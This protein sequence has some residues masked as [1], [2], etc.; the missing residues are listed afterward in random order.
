M[1][2][3]ATQRSEWK[4][5]LPGN[6]CTV[7]TRDWSCTCM[8]YKSRR[9]P[10]QHI[11]MVTRKVH[12]LNA[13]PTSTV[14]IRWSMKET[15]TLACNLENSLVPLRNVINMVK[16]RQCFARVP[17]S[18]SAHLNASTEIIDGGANATCAV[19]DA[20]SDI[21]SFF[22]QLDYAD[23]MAE[24]EADQEL[25][26]EGVSISGM[27]RTRSLANGVE[28]DASQSDGSNVPPTQASAKIVVEK[29]EDK[30]QVTEMTEKFKTPKV[31]H[32]ASHHQDLAKVSN[33]L[34]QYPVIMT[35]KFIQ[36]RPVMCGIA[37][38]S[39]ACGQS[40]QHAWVIPEPLL[41]KAEASM[42][43]KRAELSTIRK[44]APWGLTVSMGKGV[45]ILHRFVNFM[46]LLLL[47]NGTLTVVKFFPLQNEELLRPKNAN[48]KVSSR[49]PVV[50]TKMGF[51]QA[52]PVEP[53][54]LET[55][56]NGLPHSEAA[57]VHSALADDVVKKYS[58]LSLM[59]ELKTKSGRSLV[60]FRDVVS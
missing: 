40:Q 18:S 35:D 17:Q 44:S 39:D 16:A 8:F 49:Y 54:S 15:G 50:K 38:E 52:H 1:R 55:K 21:D 26:T 30:A 60:K 14:P 19:S 59:T 32:W 58:M 4:V 7:D 43:Q 46:I 9:L 5:L 25:A 42:N 28:D 27:V 29:S 11:M 48:Q 22:D 41:K 57:K 36:A 45:V 47:S 13:L 24:M 3:K 12:G 53:F 37:T 6:A 2:T 34:D 20:E 31:E 56:T 33:V 51:V 10:C 23:V